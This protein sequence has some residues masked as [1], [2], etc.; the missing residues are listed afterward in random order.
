MGYIFFAKHQPLRWF[1][2]EILVFTVGLITFHINQKPIM[3]TKTRPGTSKKSLVSHQPNLDAAIHAA[4]TGV[5][6]VIY[7]HPPNLEILRILCQSLGSTHQNSVFPEV[8]EIKADPN[9]T[10]SI[11]LSY[12]EH[13]PHTDGTFEKNP[14]PFFILQF[15]ETD[16]LGGGTSTFW[17]VQ[18]LLAQMPADYQNVLWHTPVQFQRLDDNGGKAGTIAPMLS[19]RSPNQISLRYRNDHQVYPQVVSPQSDLTLFNQALDWMKTYLAETEPVKYQAQAGDV[20][21][22]NNDA[23]F[24][25][26]TALSPQSRRLVRRVW[27]A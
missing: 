24:H 2:V 14:P 13:P 16:R 12:G 18:D 20:I 23:V 5:P 11:A 8:R 4:Q 7:N 1:F 10:K 6:V 26:R 17:S 15:V 9:S 3:L 21:I 22:I 19:Y 25:G 27:I